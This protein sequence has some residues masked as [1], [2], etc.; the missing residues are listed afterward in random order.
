MR[1]V[2][3]PS[4]DAA[5]VTMNTLPEISMLAPLAGPALRAMRPRLTLT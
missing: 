3:S 2:P 5:P 4:P 1:A